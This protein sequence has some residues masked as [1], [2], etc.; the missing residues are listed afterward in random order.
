MRPPPCNWWWQDF[1]HHLL[2]CDVKIGKT[3]RPIGVNLFCIPLFEM[4][5]AND[6]HAP[7]QLEHMSCLFS[8]KQV[9]SKRLLKNFLRLLK[10]V[11]QTF[12]AKR[13]LFMTNASSRANEKQSAWTS[14][15]QDI[16]CRKT[17]AAGTTECLVLYLCDPKHAPP[18]R[19]AENALCLHLGDAP[20][21]GGA[22]S[23]K[24]VSCRSLLQVDVLTSRFVKK[25]TERNVLECIDALV[26]Q[27]KCFKP[28]HMHRLLTTNEVKG[29][30]D[31]GTVLDVARIF[32][33]SDD[34]SVV[35]TNFSSTRDAF[36]KALLDQGF[37]ENLLFSCEGARCEFSKNSKVILWNTGDM[38]PMQCY[39]MFETLKKANVYVADPKA[40]GSLSKWIIPPLCMLLACAD[41]YVERVK[42]K[43]IV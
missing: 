22:C 28:C 3:K 6:R 12:C 30:F 18:A 41:N 1:Y 40:L 17:T 8:N 7:R 37:D 9:V 29:Y 36:K 11:V 38:F 14:V 27:D 31:R 25:V 16:A 42:L 5:L 43:F 35:I 20:R 24:K 2:K 33:E 13:V 23:V 26:W 21:S 15:A 34:Y 4:V 39:K 19:A 10:K 32:N